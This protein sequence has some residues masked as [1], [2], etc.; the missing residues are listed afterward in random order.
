MFV[1]F[2]FFIWI[3]CYWRL[4]S[5]S[6]SFHLFYILW[7]LCNDSH[8]GHTKVVRSWCDK[9]VVRARP[10]PELW[11]AETC[12][13]SL[14]GRDPFL[15]LS[16]H[17]WHTVIAA[18]LF[19]SNWIQFLIRARSSAQFCSPAELIDRSPLSSS[20]LTVQRLSSLKNRSVCVCSLIGVNAHMHKHT[21]GGVYWEE[22][23]HRGKAT[24][25]CYT[26]I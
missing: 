1:F 13:F 11:I 16:F 24:T 26:L 14:S 12:H 6:L 23:Q 2:T 25:Y 21:L 20:H 3:P 22:S 18:A 8:W 10:L 15:F 7:F 9:Q 17:C 4:F 19:P 5:R